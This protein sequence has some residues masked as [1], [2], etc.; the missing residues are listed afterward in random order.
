MMAS[1]V[2]E[3]RFVDRVN[4]SLSP[5]AERVNR[6]EL[7]PLMVTIDAAP[8]MSSHCPEFGVALV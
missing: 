4:H 6:R 1:G 2:T 7:L 8:P 3:L 5:F